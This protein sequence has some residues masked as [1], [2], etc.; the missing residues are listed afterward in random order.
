MTVHAGK[1]LRWLVNGMGG[2]G[3]VINL[4]INMAIVK[5]EAN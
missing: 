2:G 5:F 1:A 3:D 4:R